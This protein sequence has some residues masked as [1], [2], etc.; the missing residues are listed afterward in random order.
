MQ[1]ING[2][3]LGVTGRQTKSGKT[4][5]EVAF[6]DG[7]KYVTFKGDLSQKANGLVGQQVTMRVTVKQNGDFT[8]YYLE[9]I[10][11]QGQLV[12]QALPAG[13]PIQQPP[14][15]IPV[16][17]PSNGGMSPKR[18]QKIVKQNVLGTSFNFI[19]SLFQGAGPEAL[20]EAFAH[21]EK[22]AHVLYGKVMGELAHIEA[23][24]ENVAAAM[25]NAAGSEIV[26]VG[27]QNPK[28][29]LPW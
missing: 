20:D 25:N 24:P 5:Y 14:V 10:A 21:A 16:A 17:P 8:N 23:T 2:Q 6:S 15:S 7:Q 12:P 11:P 19:G 3:V 28:S 13:A 4:L 1:E 22:L 9:D 29:T 27:T 18:E 26:G